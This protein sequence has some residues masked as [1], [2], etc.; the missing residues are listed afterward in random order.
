[1]GKQHHHEHER[2]VWLPPARRRCTGQECYS[3]HDQRRP[4]VGERLERQVAHMTS[5]SVYAS[6]CWV[7][8][9]EI[10]PGVGRFQ[11]SIRI[12]TTMTPAAAATPLITNWPRRSHD[13]LLAIAQPSRRASDG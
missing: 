1:M 4:Q 11:T 12:N 6:G 13:T 2:E 5:D 8:A 3:C 7:R 10:S 9:R